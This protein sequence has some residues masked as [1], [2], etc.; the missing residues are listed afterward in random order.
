MQDASGVDVG[1]GGGS[2][3]RKK[4]NAGWSRIGVGVCLVGDGKGPDGKKRARTGRGMENVEV[5]PGGGQGVGGGGV[6][7]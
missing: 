1:C 3:Y 6:M 2:L 4:K 7:L 5:E